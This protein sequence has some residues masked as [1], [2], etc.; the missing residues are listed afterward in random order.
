MAGETD[1]T[2]RY[3]IDAV[4][5]SNSV[6]KRYPCLIV[7]NGSNIGQSFR[8]K[9]R[10]MVIGRSS[11]A[12]IALN[13]PSISRY[14]AEIVQDG[15]AAV[16]CDLGS[17]NGTFLEDQRISRHQLSD[18]D[19]VRLG[20]TL[21]VR[22][23]HLDEVEQ[24]MQTELYEGSVRDALTGVF[25][26]KVFNEQLKREFS[27]SQRYGTPLSLVMIDVDHFKSVNDQHGHPVGDEV[28]MGI[29]ERVIPTVRLEDCFARYGGE[30]FVVLLRN[31]GAHAATEFAERLRN[32][33][34]GKA[35][36][37]RRVQANSA[38]A[39]DETEAETAPV[40]GTIEL[41]ITVSL[42][43]ACTEGNSYDAA[44]ALLGAADGAL[45]RAKEGGRNRVCS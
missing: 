4:A 14:H 33:I 10:R 1:E 21:V 42:G 2:I 19:R 22:F 7:I 43:V 11:D 9:S 3:D 44:P 40:E 12:D 17:T 37:V 20:A 29:A 28:L 26:R 38:S 32:L 8:I 27:F 18:G 6:S 45:Y 34:A 24:R 39:G 25:N 13:D 30:E 16:L 35:F 15:G 41:P 23:D 31:A 5:V 36:S